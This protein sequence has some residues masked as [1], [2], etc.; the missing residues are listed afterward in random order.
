MPHPLPAATREEMGVTP[1]RSLQGSVLTPGTV[2][3]A[4]PER[5]V[6]IHQPHTS[7]HLLG[8]GKP[9]IPLLHKDHRPPCTP[10]LGDPP[11]LPAPRA[12]SCTLNVGMGFAST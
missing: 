12:Q 9:Q 5:A 8:L 3:G 6:V 11:Q 4:S 1:G 7:H 10:Q 2:A